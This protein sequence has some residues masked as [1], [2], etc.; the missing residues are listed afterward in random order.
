MAWGLEKASFHSN[1]KEEHC[2]R[3]FRLPYNYTHFTS[4]QGFS[5]TWTENFQMYNLDLGKADEIANISLI[6]GKAREFQKKKS[7][8]TS[9][10]T[11]KPFTV[12]ITTNCGRFL[13]R[14][15]YK[16]TVPAFW[17][18]CMLVEKQLLEPDME[19]QTGSNWEGTMS[20]LY[21]VTLFM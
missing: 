11:V 14:W 20:R 1:L 5:S 8:S 16:T 3:M 2:Q 9:L 21:I 15:E 19:W 18:I 10:T 7:T 6:I 17:E 13:K 4:L 12:W